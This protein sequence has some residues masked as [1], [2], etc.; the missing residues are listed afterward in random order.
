MKTEILRP[1]CF[2]EPTTKKRSWSWRPSLNEKTGND[3]FVE[4]N[5][6]WVR[7]G[8]LFIRRGTKR[9]KDE[10]TEVY[11]SSWLTASLYILIYS[12]KCIWI[13]S[14]N[15]LLQCHHGSK[16]LPNHLPHR[17]VADRK[18]HS[19]CNFPRQRKHCYTT[20]LLLE[21]QCHAPWA[22]VVEPFSLWVELGNQAR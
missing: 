1:T 14:T 10:T 12:I 13:W 16:S 19:Q 4:P 15:F 6:L 22:V 5:T 8:F 2:S 9:I 3:D 17:N 11:G 7:D 20:I 21:P 18:C